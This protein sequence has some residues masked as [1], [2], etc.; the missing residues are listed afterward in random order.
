MA[1]VRLERFRLMSGLAESQ[2]S[3][4]LALLAIRG[5]TVLANR[6]CGRHFGDVVESVTPSGT[7]ATLSIPGHGYDPSGTVL[8]LGTG[9]AGLTGEVSY[10][11]VDESTLSV[12]GV[13]I[14]VPITKGFAAKKIISKS[15]VMDLVATISPSPVAMV[16]EVRMRSVGQDDGPF[17]SSS[18]LANSEW[19]CDTREPSL[20]GELEVYRNVLVRKRVPGMIKPVVQ[21]SLKEIEVTYYAGFI[22]GIPEDLQTAICSIGKELATDSAGGFAQESY[23]DYSYQRMDPE[24]LRRLP[25][26]ALSTLARYQVPY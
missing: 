13:T 23:E 18:T 1:A 16:K 25:A 7:N 6:F 21:R 5:A 2:L 8:L 26:S 4:E 3:S 9:I 24:L 12:S 22:R 19:F 17:P 10:Q 11:V 15:R 14:S 20:S